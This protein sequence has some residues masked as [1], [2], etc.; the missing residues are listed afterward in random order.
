MPNRPMANGV[1]L[2]LLP[3]LQGFVKQGGRD[4]AMTNRSAHCSPVHMAHPLLPMLHAMLCCML[5]FML[6]TLCSMLC[7][8][9]AVPF[10]MQCMLS[11]AARLL[12]CRVVVV[13]C[14]AVLPC[15]PAHVQQ[16]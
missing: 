14:M 13:R 8:L 12:C 5:H 3:Q 11:V 9:R 15:L 1:T 10:A 2:Q 7:M 4:T 6:C 16:V